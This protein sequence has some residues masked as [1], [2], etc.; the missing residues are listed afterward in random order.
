MTKKGDVREGLSET[1]TTLADDEMQF[2]V[3][4]QAPRKRPYCTPRFSGL[5]PRALNRAASAGGATTMEADKATTLAA[6]HTLVSALRTSSESAIRGGAFATGD[7]TY[8]VVRSSGPRREVRET[9][10]GRMGMTGTKAMVLLVAIVLRRDDVV[11]IWMMWMLITEGWPC[12][13][14]CT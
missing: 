9:P 6:T 5:S 3:G 11:E 14:Q 12:E 13:I 1:R 4:G 7:V 8:R 10:D 2:R